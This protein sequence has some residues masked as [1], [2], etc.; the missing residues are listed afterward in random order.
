MRLQQVPEP[1]EF[2]AV[3]LELKNRAVRLLPEGR[4]LPEAVWQRRHRAIIRLCLLSA[5]TLVL[6][7]WGWGYGQ[8]A[9]VFILAAVTAPLV[10]AV[11]PRLGRKFQAS[12]TTLSLMIAS[13]TL[14]HLWSGVTESHFIFFVMVGVV[15]L[16]QDWVPYGVALLVV[17]LHHGVIGT[18]YPHVVFGHA[19]GHDPWV[20]A[21]IHAAFVL[22]ASL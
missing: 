5:A 7:S 1:A 9:A 17:L 20:W 15:S 12:G 21:S 11:H 13:A 18:M 14:V 4:L 8:P 22:A 10:L 16:Y 3:I 19:G 6:L 2:P